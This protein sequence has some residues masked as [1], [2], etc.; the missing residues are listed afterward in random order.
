M[1][2]DDHTG[3]TPRSR[4]DGHAWRDAQKRVSERNDE[5]SKASRERQ[6]EHERHIAAL[7][8]SAEQGQ[9]RIYR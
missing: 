6:A 9:G 8:R 5:A 1:S 3:E 2:A 4:P 7:K